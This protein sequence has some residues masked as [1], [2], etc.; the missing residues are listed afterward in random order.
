M[1]G[2]KLG[3]QRLDGLPGF[4]QE[5]VAGADVGV[6][7]VEGQLRGEELAAQVGVGGLEGGELGGGWLGGTHALPYALREE[8]GAPLRAG[9]RKQGGGLSACS[10]ALSAGLF[11]ALAVGSL[12]CLSH[13]LEVEEFAWVG[14]LGGWCGA[15]VVVSVLRWGRGGGV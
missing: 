9:G 5:R 2:G 13:L 1:R 4:E 15:G 12:S 7:L 11:S 14:G 8:R 10:V 6:G 3:A